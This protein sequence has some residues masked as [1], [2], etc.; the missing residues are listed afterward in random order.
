[1]AFHLSLAVALFTVRG[2]ASD[3]GDCPFS[4]SSGALEVGQVLLQRGLSE[5]R[6]LLVEHKSTKA[7]QH[8]N[9]TDI[10]YRK[11]VI[12]V[13]SWTTNI[14]QE[15]HKCAGSRFETNYSGTR[16]GM[17]VADGM[18]LK[19]AKCA[20][21]AH[22]NSSAPLTTKGLSCDSA[23]TGCH[24]WCAPVWLSFKDQMYWPGFDE[25]C[26]GWDGAF[27]SSDTVC[28]DAG[29]VFTWARALLPPPDQKNIIDLT[30]AIT[31]GCSSWC[32]PLWVTLYDPKEWSKSFRWCFNRKDDWGNCDESIDV[33]ENTWHDQQVTMA[34]FTSK[35]GYSP[36]HFAL[37]IAAYSEFDGAEIVLNG[38]KLSHVSENG[39]RNLVKVSN[40]PD[41]ETCGNDIACG[42]DH[43]C[44][45]KGDS[46][47][48]AMCCPI[49]WSCCE[50]SCCP[51]AFTCTITDAG[52]T[53]LPV[54]EDNSSMTAPALCSLV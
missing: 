41:A 40:T 2:F 54:L 29:R 19:K 9:D 22:S 36:E 53:C 12:D 27:Q 30:F 49:N 44:C 7:S 17:V 48:D 5:T 11:A 37:E 33:A 34:Q 6:S 1:M 26:K 39:A 47:V 35:H 46:E 4:D 50:D 14:G 21:A 16:N 18:L 38:L 13:L 23:A 3:V 43:Q 51:T 52:H 45:R 8:K 24:M 28:A 10:K 25:R 15:H 32:A 42:D 20:L 31:G